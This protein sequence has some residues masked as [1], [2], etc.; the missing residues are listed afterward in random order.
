M[1]EDETKLRENVYK[2]GAPVHELF[3]AVQ[4]AYAPAE[5]LAPTHAWIV[6]GMAQAV[7]YQWLARS[8]L[9]FK[10]AEHRYYDIPL[11]KP[12]CGR[13][14]GERQLGCYAT[15][16]FW[17]WLGRRFGSRDGIQYLQTLLQQDLAPD[18]GLPGIDQ[19]LRQFD[20]D[21]LYNLLPA[22]IADFAD[23]RDFYEHAGNEQVVFK[24][25]KIEKT[26]ARTVA[27]VAADAFVLAVAMPTSEHADLELKFRNQRDDLHLIVDKLRSDIARPRNEYTTR[28][29]STANTFLVRVVNVARKAVDSQSRDY[30]LQ[31]TLE[32]PPDCKIRVQWS[33]HLQQK[34]FSGTYEGP[35][36][37]HHQV[38]VGLDEDEQTI[39]FEFRFKDEELGYYVFTLATHAPMAAPGETAQT[40]ANG[41]I[42]LRPAQ[43]QYQMFGWGPRS[44]GFTGLPRDDG[45][46]SLTVEHH[47]DARLRGNLSALLTNGVK[48]L[49]NDV[50]GK[51]HVDAS[52][53]LVLG[54]GGGCASD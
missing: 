33:G 2:M 15:F 22:F 5:T 34:G 54:P 10:P 28:L 41:G 43:Y 45:H 35:V 21:G 46:V 29:S 16:Q 17:T 26:I 51:M 38:N 42:T 14:N 3:H 31:L 4:M 44:M 36:D 37:E 7:L 8:R 27:P 39:G 47:D 18:R 24:G 53:D 19:G 9:D 48:P 32:P 49:S 23:S 12:R 6:E 1:G 25:E 40:R 50:A 11:H 13:A 30:E 20:A 52:F